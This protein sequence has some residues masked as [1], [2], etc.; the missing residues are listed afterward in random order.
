MQIEQL[1]Q[2]VGHSIVAPRRSTQLYRF[3]TRS[4]WL[5]PTACALRAL[6]IL[7]VAA[8]LL[9][10]P[11][12]AAQKRRGSERVRGEGELMR[13]MKE[14]TGEQMQ[15]HDYAAAEASLR[16]SIA[17]A[18]KR[19]A[20]RVL[21][22]QYDQ[23][24]QI[25]MERGHHAE[26]EALLR[27]SLPMREEIFGPTSRQTL[28]GLGHL[29]KVLRATGKYGEADKVL[30]DALERQA[31]V[32]QAGD[33]E[34]TR[35][36]T[37]YAVLLR[38]I[39][40]L[41]RAEE[42]YK[43]AIDNASGTADR[44]HLQILANSH[45]NYAQLL[46]DRNA[47]AEAEAEARAALVIDEQV[48]GAEHGDVARSLIQLG[49]T[50]L[51]QGRLDEAETAL[52]RS[53]PLC[54][55]YIGKMTDETAG[56]WSG[57]GMALEQRGKFQEADDAMRHSVEISAQAATQGHRLLRTYSYG[58]FLQRQN[59]AEE[60]LVYFK[61]SLDLI[62]A[63]FA[64]T[65]GLNEEARQEFASRYTPMYYQTVQTL[66]QLHRAKPQ[67]GYDRDALALVSRTQS[68]LFTEMLRQSDVSKFSADPRFV[69][70]K[71]ERDEHMRR[72]ADLR[73]GR[74]IAYSD[75]E[76]D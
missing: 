1:A 68:R 34:L 21:A 22:V 16:K 29:G 39:G 64:S 52:R 5:Q 66:L 71:R 37:Q 55:K 42:Y 40:Q 27:K 50:L 12:A 38:T 28:R 13:Q 58:R 62:E 30:R 11:P 75:A 60:A 46:R 7:V 4:N 73:R 19:G 43:K 74:V 54:E 47:L 59:R 53:L 24:G 72:A 2:R 56:A 70:L 67:A 8:A 76:V 48:H 45:R 17:I 36:L 14:Q 57:L 41:A 3:A 6:V 33:V 32:A 51:R 35:A 69:Q 15:Q 65:R 44:H 49:D 26:A 9:L 18:E 20:K 25:E 61:Q 23:L 31:S 63:G 10:P